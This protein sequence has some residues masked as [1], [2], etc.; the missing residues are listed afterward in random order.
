[1]KEDLEA[2]FDGQDLSEEFVERTTTL[3]E[4]A[5]SA[6]LIAETARIEEEYAAKLEEEVAVISEEL[7]NKLD[8]Y[9]TY[10]VENFMKENQVAI[11]STLRNELAEEFMEG[12]KNLFA[13]HYISVPQEKIDVL[14]A[15]AEKVDQLEGKLNQAIEENNELRGVLVTEAAKG[16]FS[17]LASDLAMTQQEKFAAL[18]EGIEFDGDLDTYA[19]KLSIIKESYFNSEMAQPSSHLE[20]ETFEGDVGETVHIDPQVN[21]YVQA[22]AKTIKK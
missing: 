6:R 4:A 2:I 20:E 22:I 19:R 15:M 9:L 3:F 18:A 21:R 7:T 8:S 12:L 10:S 5:L 13:E 16:I 17:E 11:E 14:E 1:M